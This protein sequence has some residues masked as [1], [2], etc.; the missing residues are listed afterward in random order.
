MNNIENKIKEEFKNRE[1]SPNI[2]SWDKLNFKLHSTQEK[3]KIKS[4]FILEL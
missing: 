1:I 4:L 3:K 2:S